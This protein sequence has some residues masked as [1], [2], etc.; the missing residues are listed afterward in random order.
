LKKTAVQI[1]RKDIVFQ[2]QKAEEL[3]EGSFLNEAAEGYKDPVSTTDC[4]QNSS[5]TGY[6]IKTV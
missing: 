5:L 2:L 3:N 6:N 4:S 1:K